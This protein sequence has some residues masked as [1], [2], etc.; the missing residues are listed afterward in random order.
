MKGQ[1]IL[2]CLFYFR[3]ASLAC[4][5]LQYNCLFFN[6]WQELNFNLFRSY[7]MLFFF[8]L[9]QFLI[10]STM[11]KITLNVAL[12]LAIGLVSACDNKKDGGDNY[13][14]PT[15]RIGSGHGDE[16]GIGDG[17]DN[18]SGEDVGM[19]NPG[20]TTSIVTGK[21]GVPNYTTDPEFVAMAA[22]SGMLE[23]ELGKVAAQK[24][25]N[26]EVKKFANQ[27]VTDHGKANSEL[28]AFGTK[29]GISV[30]AYMS[31][32]D[33][34]VHDRIAKLS[35]ASFDRD[36]MAQ[37]VLDHE[38]AVGMFENA[39]RQATD[40]DLK[41]WASKTLPTLRNHLEMARSLNDKVK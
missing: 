4:S 27:M 8:I 2:S 11:K 23:V 33:Q 19:Q 16:L 3:R 35:G 6:Y 7:K 26:A 41:S 14:T 32:E 40:A 34:A 9:S 17:D 31:A 21:P 20:D 24:A 10:P 15:E 25:T 18:T 38:K 28:K 22:S 29:K 1:D 39:N 36:Y 5:V 13:S 30:P 37:M 12:A